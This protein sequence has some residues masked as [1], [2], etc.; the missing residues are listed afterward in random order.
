MFSYRFFLN[1]A[2]NITKR[3]RHLW[4]FGIFASLTAIGGEYQIIAQGMNNNPGG[5]FVGTGFYMFYNL[6]NPSFYEGIRNLASTNP[7]MLWS[8]IT[9]SLL[10]LA[11]VAV[12]MY[13]AIVSQAALVE[14][15][16]QI[17]ISKKKKES[18]SI[19]EGLVSGRRHFW[20]VLALNITNNFVITLSFFLISLPLIFLLI[21]DTGALTFAY[22]LLFII[23]VPISLSIA[24]IIKYAIASRVLEETSFVASIVRGWSIFQKNWLVSLEMAL[25]LFL[26]NF[27]AGVITIATIFLFFLPLLVLSLQLYAPVLTGISFILILTAMI[28]AASILNTFQISTWTGL[29]LHLQEKKGRS[30][31][32]RIFQR[33]R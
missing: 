1:Q 26:I 16:A 7:S 23:F 29:Y 24:L 31:L 27:A 11:L 32:E 18:L 21:T 4:F 28:A 33:K 19:S 20:R 9:A 30:K 5:S 13:L 8:L 10:V 6:F 17:I 12:M 14:Q 3:Y 25:L 15:S 22:T 2:W